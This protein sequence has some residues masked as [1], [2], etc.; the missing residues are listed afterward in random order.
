MTN[1][2]KNT[3]KKIVDRTPSRMGKTKDRPYNLLGFLNDPIGIIQDNLALQELSK[4]DKNGECMDLFDQYVFDM[5]Y[6]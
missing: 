2:T 5:M 3:I 6:L 4:Y 1:A